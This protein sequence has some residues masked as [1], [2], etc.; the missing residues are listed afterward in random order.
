MSNTKIVIIKLLVYTIA[1]FLFIGGVWL[2]KRPQSG[3]LTQYELPENRIVVNIKTDVLQNYLSEDALK[4][5]KNV[6][7]KYKENLYLFFKSVEFKPIDKEHM[8]TFL[9]EMEQDSLIL[10]TQEV[11]PDMKWDAEDG[12]LTLPRRRPVANED[13]VAMPTWLLV[14]LIDQGFLPREGY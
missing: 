3:V 10:K 13:Y 4:D 12:V 14:K 1:A 11:L 8:E 2:V 5:K 6:W 9:K 7:F